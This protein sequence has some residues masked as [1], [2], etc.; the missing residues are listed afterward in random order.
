MKLHKDLHTF[1]ELLASAKV[2]FLVVGGHAVAFHGHPRFTGDIDLWV[3]AVPQN[4]D[5]VLA[6][7]TAF[8]FADLGVTQDDLLRP[9]SIVQLGRPP[10]R[11]DLLTSISGVNFDEA[12]ASKVGGRLDDLEVWYLG[13][14][15]LVTNKRA[16]NRPKDLADLHELLRPKQG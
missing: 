14:E 2:E 8:G 6:V 13:R 7:L 5:R 12:W 4:A 3:R 11:I 10:H 1:V 9:E 15:A 16:S